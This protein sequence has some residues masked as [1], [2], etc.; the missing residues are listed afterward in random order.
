MVIGGKLGIAGPGGDAHARSLLAG[1]G[2]HE[3]VR[4]ALRN[5]EELN[6]YPLVDHPVDVTSALVA[7]VSDHIVTAKWTK[8]RG[9]SPLLLGPR[10]S[11]PMN[12]AMIG[13]HYAQVVF[14]GRK[15]HRQINGSMA[16]F[17]PGENARRFQRPARRLAV[18]EL[19]EATFLDAVDK[20]GAADESWLPDDPGLSLYLRP[21]MF[22]TESNLM[23]RPSREYVFLVIAFVAGGFFG[24]TV[25]PVSVWV[26][27]DHTRAPR[28][29]PAT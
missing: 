2:D 20:V 1:F 27:H 22:A 3:A 8:G 17:R 5:G 29:A 28:A 12:P 7:D 24:D 18:P 16:V 19:P 11:I 10:E 4:A 6:G 9:W 23:L 26:S 14:E 25:K 21:L 13:L 15:A